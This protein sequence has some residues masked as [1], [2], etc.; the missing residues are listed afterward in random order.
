MQTRTPSIGQVAIAIGFA[1]S[2]FGLLL[3]LWVAFGGPVPLKSTGYRVTV[4]VKEAT[5]LGVEADVRM[6]GVPVGKVKEVALGDGNDAEATLELDG[7]HAPLPSD[8]RAI[9]RQKTLLG[10]T[11]IE[12]TPGSDDAPPVPEGGTLN[13][14]QVSES[15]QL[16]EIYR[17]FDPQ[18]RQAFQVWM[19]DGAESVE[20][21]AADLN[22]AFGNLDPFTEEGARLM[23]T[24]DGQRLAV[25]RLV[26]DGGE[27]FEALSERQGALR[28]LITNS[29]SVFATTA[30][31][32]RELTEIFRVLPTFLRE[33]RTTLTRVDRFAADTDPLITQL[34]P[35]AR[36]LGPTVGEI[37][38]LAPRIE[39]FFDGL[40]P[41]TRLAPR[42]FGSL[43]G[44]LRDDLTP[45]LTRL[46]PFTKELVPVLAA[47]REYR[48]EVT[49]FF[50]NAA[51]AT[52]AFTN[53]E[54][55]N[56]RRV[57]YLRSSSPLHPEMLAGYTERLG[58]NRT[59]PYTKPGGYTELTRALESFQ[60]NHCGSPQSGIIDL[61]DAALFPDDLLERIHE[62][63][64]LE[65][66]AGPGN[67]VSS[68]SLPAPRCAKQAPFRSLGG[69]P[70]ESSNYLH[71][72]PEE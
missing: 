45:L 26:H 71:V 1:L 44:L 28:G 69:P 68:A 4:P 48:R 41:V 22:A 55:G 20:G 27:V 32:D 46:T 25:S 56:G 52:N 12:L 54:E 11:Y 65:R 42:G 17:T 21:R 60:T 62:Y 67:L 70:R 61:D 36:E 29:E 14:S 47:V 5:Q 9:L 30:E 10:E 18:T 58:I 31:R 33:S 38:R 24:L 39:R 37:E 23:R 57:R 13:A 35:A 66:P 50:A 8:S 2:C 6:S 59:N 64:F 3:F 7:E 16:D 19:Q 40:L 72:R 15:V 34:R 43:R 51:A 53:P 63:V 49:A